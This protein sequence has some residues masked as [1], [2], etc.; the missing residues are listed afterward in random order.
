MV[1]ALANPEAQLPEVFPF[2]AELYQRDL[3]AL[4]RQHPQVS[5]SPRASGGRNVPAET[6]VAFL[7][8]TWPPLLQ[9]TLAQ[10]E[11]FVAVEMLSAVALVNQALEDGDSRSFWRSLLSSALGLAN[12]EESHAQR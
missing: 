12:V 6:A 7:V 9:G 8:S 1:R 11:L 10:E 5:G 3:L 4:Q 2:A